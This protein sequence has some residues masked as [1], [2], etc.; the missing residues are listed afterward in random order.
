MKNN[1]SLKIK[2][3]GAFIGSATSVA[4]AL[5][6]S[7]FGSAAYA[8]D[9]SSG[10]PAAAAVTPQPFKAIQVGHAENGLLLSVTAADKRLIAVGG[11]GAIISSNDG[12]QW[13]QM[14][15]PVD[16]TLTGVAFADGKH[17]WAVG[18]DALILYTADGGETWSIQNF[19]PDLNS[20]MFAVVAISPTQALAVGAF[21][22]LKSTSDAGASWKDVEAPALSTEKYHLNG[23]AQ[24]PQ[25][26][27][28]VVGEGGLAGYSSDGLQWKRLSVPYTGSLFG[29]APWG[30]NG[31][32]AYGMGG[33][34]FTTDDVKENHWKKLNMPVGSSFFGSFPLP[35]GKLGLVGGENKTV[36][37]DRSGAATV[38]S[39]A[40]EGGQA[41]ALAG[42]V[43]R[44]GQLIV[45]GERGVRRISQK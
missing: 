12:V 10:A 39:S 43:S 28:I 45:V 31:A 11:N 44:D 14:P 30:E 41:T 40:S 6:V 22:T 3:I 35:D 9:I 42:G 18:H 24:L 13:K 2:R 17:G 5:V 25:Q 8:Q 15:S 4:F 27:F 26:G 33:N 1:Q 29:V 36:V 7:Q 37:V 21:G 19:Q 23:I 34:V 38:I 20:P 16:V 32:I